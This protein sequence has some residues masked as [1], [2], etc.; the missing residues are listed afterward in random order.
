MSESDKIQ[1]AFLAR[2]L[3]LLSDQRPPKNRKLWEM[4]VDGDLPAEQEG[5]RWFV[6]RADLP[7]IVE[8]LRRAETARA[9]PKRVRYSTSSA[10]A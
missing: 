9:A 6:K 2:E 10:A 3:R 8:I 4:I 1:L 7:A 5:G